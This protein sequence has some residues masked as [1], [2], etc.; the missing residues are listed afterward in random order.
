[1]GDAAGHGLLSAAKWLEPSVI[2]ASLALI[3]ALIGL[4]LPMWRTSLA[5]QLNNPAGEESAL[6]IS[7]PAGFQRYQAWIGR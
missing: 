4:V 7:S 5:E 2:V 1:M 6:L 3:V